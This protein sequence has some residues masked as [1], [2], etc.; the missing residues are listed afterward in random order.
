MLEM[1]RRL[2]LRYKP[3]QFTFR[4]FDNAATIAQLHDL[5]IQLNSFQ[6]CDLDKI[7][8]VRTFEF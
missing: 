7:L 8:R 4:R 5:A 3:G 1:G 6:G 2:V